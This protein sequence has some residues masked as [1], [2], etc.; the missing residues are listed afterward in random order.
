MSSY[1]IWLTTPTGD[2][3]KLLD[4]YTRLRYVLTVNAIG[5]ATVELPASFPLASYVQEDSRLEIWRRTD[6]GQ[7]YLEGDAV[8]F[9][10]DWDEVLSQRGT[11]SFSIVAYSPNE[12]LDRPIIAYPS[13]SAQAG[14]SGIEADNLIKAFVR[15][16]MGDEATDT[17]RDLSAYLTIMPD[18]SAGPTSSK[19]AA[20]RRL[21]N[22]LRDIAQQSDDAGTPLFFG[23]TYNP[24]VRLLTFATRINQWGVDHS[25][26]ADRVV[27]SP[28]NGSLGQVERAYVS[29]AERNYAYVGGQGQEDSRTIYEAGNAARIAISPF[30]RREVFVEARNVAEDDLPDEGAAALRAARVRETF[31]AKVRDTQALQYGRDYGFGDRVLAEFRGRLAPARL[32]SV[33]VLVQ[34][35]RED[36]NTVLRVDE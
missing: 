26:I 23:I 9:I 30:N 18:L 15:E 2:R 10:R 7:S 27:L 32:D 14:K 34:G 12:L 22:T 11:E 20:W 28:R 4:R 17:D 33:E 3:L 31:S 1:A 25:T 35:G 24:E 36:V 21:L 5:A 29:S 19:S 6:G 16:N 8:W 13:G